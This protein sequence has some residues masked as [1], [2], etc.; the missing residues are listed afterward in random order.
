MTP[1]NAPLPPFIR[2][3]SMEYAILSIHEAYREADKVTAAFSEGSGIACPEGCH[4]RC[5]SDFEPDVTE[6]E[7]LYLAAWI[8]L[9]KREDLEAALSEGRSGGCPLWSEGDRAHCRAYAGRALICRL[10]GFAALRD[11]KGE[12]SFSLCFAMR[13]VSR[14][15][16]RSWRA[17]DLEGALGAD[18]PVM[19][20]F[21]SRIAAL[22]PGSDRMALG[23]ALKSALSRLKLAR[24]FGAE[25]DDEDPDEIDRESA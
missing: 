7:A 20:E 5:C 22:S 6:A 18:A 21:G 24:R 19:G 1:E 3:T 25:R 15:A 14:G 13:D 2:G 10:F 12:K 23:P 17:A 4:G 16:A 8:I 11:S 9:E